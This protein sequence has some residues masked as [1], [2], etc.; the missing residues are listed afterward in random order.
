M[1]L[2]NYIYYFSSRFI[3]YLFY[4]S[5]FIFWKSE[6]REDEINESF[7]YNYHFKLSQKKRK[8]IISKNTLRCCTWN[9]H[10][11]Y[12]I[13]H[14]YTMPFI[15]SYLKEMDFDVI[16]LQEV[17]NTV[18]T[19]HDEDVTITTY[20]SKLLDMESIHYNGLSI[21]SKFPIS[22]IKSNSY[23]VGYNSFGNHILRCNINLVNNK[24]FTAINTHL[25]SDIVG[26]EQYE[27]IAKLGLD[28]IIH[29]HNNNSSNL[30]IVGDFNSPRLF[31]LNH[32]FSNMFH[33][34][35]PNNALTFPTIYPIANLDK[36]WCNQK[37]ND[38]KINYINCD[39]SIYYSDH[40]PL[41]YELVLDYNISVP[42]L[43]S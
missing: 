13:T 1:N 31:S 15:T 41:L 37:N 12:D 14:N 22:D 11:G 18:F 17:N 23:Y 28:N 32:Y 39:N 2:F 7:L 34:T 3:N 5:S 35:D 25:N 29:E 6:G 16:F 38:L 42:V 4:Y 40:F 9:I 36:V 27:S 30:V 26:Y 20:L 43:I 24:T 8:E 33:Q 19:I 21:L 10:R